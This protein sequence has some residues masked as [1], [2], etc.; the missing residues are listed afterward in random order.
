MQRA[1]SLP[2]ES[3]KGFTSFDFDKETDQSFPRS[4]SKTELCQVLTGP[5]RPN[6]FRPTQQPSHPSPTS[7]VQNPI[8]YSTAFVSPSIPAYTIVFPNPPMVMATR[9]DPLVLPTQLHD[10]PQG[11]AQRIRIYDVEGD[12]LA[13]QHLV[14]FN[15]FCEL[16]DVDYDDAKMI[17]FAKRF[18]GE[19]REWFRGYLL[20][21]FIMSK[22]LKPFFLENVRGRRTLCTC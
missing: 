17:L 12:F 16:E 10:L 19:V 22:N 5:E 14:K 9:Y 13:Q 20:E 1:S 6:I 15:D 3:V 4:K 7:V 2:T 11:Y 8:T 18:G 21:A